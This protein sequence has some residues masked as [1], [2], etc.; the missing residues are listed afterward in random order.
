MKQTQSK[1][2]AFI[3]YL[4][5]HREDRAM[6]A[7]LRRG[8]GKVPG[9]EPETFPYVVPFL[10]EGTRWAQERATFLVASLYGQ[11]PLPGG[12]GSLGAS[13]HKM[14]AKASESLDKRF[15]ALLN[16]HAD[17][18]HHSLRHIVSLL[19]SYDVPVDWLQLLNDL[20]FWSHEDRFIQRS[21][22]KDYWRKVMTEES[23]SAEST[24]E[25]KTE[26]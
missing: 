14:R 12:S 24:E 25:S 9:T 23:G 13:L 4:R 22:A 8:L 21:W 19:R 7:G 18:L 11:H 6:L 2:E 26:E 10:S 3:E 17:D 5:S 1:N 20:P 16:A 15:T